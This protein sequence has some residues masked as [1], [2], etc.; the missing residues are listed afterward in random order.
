MVPA[1][2]R[3]TEKGTEKDKKRTEKGERKRGQKKDFSIRESN[4]YFRA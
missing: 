1:G 4:T 2:T 3:P